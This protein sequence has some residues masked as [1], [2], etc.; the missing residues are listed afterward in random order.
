MQVANPNYDP[1][2]SLDKGTVGAQTATVGGAVTTLLLVAVSLIN[3]GTLDQVVT[4]GAVSAVATLASAATA[5]YLAWRRNR[6]KHR[7]QSASAPPAVGL[8]LPLC[9]ALAVS[10]LAAG[11]NTTTLPDGTVVHSLDPGVIDT[12]F[13]AWE[14]LDQRRRDLEEEKAA[15]A[16]RAD[17]AQVEAIEKQL[18]VLGP[19]L[20]DAWK[21]VE[22]RL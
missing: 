16:A 12:A 1:N 11:C 9:L 6:K 3:G 18:D 17:A 22:G 14:R 15:A 7:M 8:L 13:R 10:G 19:E 4:T 2:I 5:G 21:R 20:E